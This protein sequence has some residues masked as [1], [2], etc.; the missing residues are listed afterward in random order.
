MIELSVFCTDFDK[1]QMVALIT[2]VGG[3]PHAGRGD[4]GPLDG[5]AVIFDYS[6]DGVRDILL[7]EFGHS[8]GNLADEYSYDSLSFQP[9]QDVNCDIA[10][11]EIA[12]PKWCSGQPI[13]VEELKNAI[14]NDVNDKESCVNKY[15][16]GMPCDWIRETKVFGET[17]CVNELSL[18]APITDKEICEGIHDNYA[19]DSLCY[20]LDTPDPYFKSN[21]IPTG[22]DGI[23]IGIDCIANTGCYKVCGYMDWFRSSYHSRMGG[24]TYA[25]DGTHSWQYI[26]EQHLISLLESMGDE[27]PEGTSSIYSEDR[28]QIIY[29]DKVDENGA[30]I[31]GGVID[32]GSIG[33]SIKVIESISSETTDECLSGCICNK[34]VTIC[35]TENEPVIAQIMPEYVGDEGEGPS[36]G[37]LGELDTGSLGATISMIREGNKLKIKSGDVE[38]ITSETVTVV[39]SKLTM[40]TSN[41]ASA[42]IKIMPEVASQ[43]A[44]DKLGDLGFEIEL[45]EVGIGDDGNIVYELKAEKQGHILALFKKTGEIT[46]QID[47]ESGDI[48]SVKKPW[49]SFLATGI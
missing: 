3:I 12:C 47:A 29:Y 42:E 5:T 24:G 32:Q 2:G 25:I 14:C 34:A 45:K 16:Q 22:A 18:C 19:I 7:H 21:C 36:R 9:P 30:I 49:W 11:S 17:G 20:W 6:G 26:H 43:T 46:T 35:S 39:D 15:K 44:I 13:E 48:I 23:N 27:G 8:F 41:G 33:E 4:P 37:S 28:E 1:M 10:S 38:V 40:Q 31:N